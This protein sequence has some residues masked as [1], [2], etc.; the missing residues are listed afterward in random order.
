MKTQNYRQWIISLL[1]LFLFAPVFYGEKIFS[2]YF[3]IVII[4]CT[5]PFF[6]EYSSVFPRLVVFTSL[7][8]LL[9]SGIRHTGNNSGLIIASYSFILI[10]TFYDIK[11]IGKILFYSGILILTFFIV[12]NYKNLIINGFEFY[13]L[14]DKFFYPHLFFILAVISLLLNLFSG[15]FSKSS[16]EILNVL[17]IGVL[18]FLVVD[19]FKIYKKSFLFS[20]FIIKENLS[21]ENFYIDKTLSVAAESDLSNDLKK[22]V[23]FSE[24]NFDV[25]AVMTSSYHHETKIEKV[26]TFNKKLFGVDSKNIY[27]INKKR[28]LKKIFTLNNG[29]IKDFNIYQNHIYF[30][31]Y[32]GNLFKKHIDENLIENITS[33]YG[34]TE[35]FSFYNGELIK[36]NNSWS[37]SVFN[38]ERNSDFYNIPYKKVVFDSKFYYSIS[39]N[40]INSNN[41]FSFNVNEGKASRVFNRNINIYDFAINSNGEILFLDKK[42]DYKCD[43]IYYDKNKNFKIL[44]YS[45]GSGFLNFI[46]DE[47]F[48]II[49]DN[50]I[51]FYKL[52]N[53]PTYIM[54]G[55]TTEEKLKVVEKIIE[56]NNGIKTKIQY[57]KKGDFFTVKISNRSKDLNVIVSRLVF[58]AGVLANLFRFEN[59]Q[60]GLII[61]TEFYKDKILIST[62][63]RIFAD[64]LNTA[65]P[66]YVAENINLKINNTTFRVKGGI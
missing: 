5:Y 6:F 21:I 44:P 30:S 58:S 29:L 26:L 4:F 23:V 24:K 39:D 52:E 1:I 9:F 31:D 33:E 46:N 43:L 50:L 28:E 41:L 27:E 17:I 16:I 25:Y 34:K 55:E 59:P 51:T 32:E 10:L 64:A 35:F 36:Y 54:I 63:V 49:D 37:G 14:G 11:K 60:S 48:A 66:G 47:E 22:Y 12:L 2:L 42:S 45:G 38:F 7:S 53:I 20:D 40:L 3:F 56:K 8:V 61:E 13:L 18:F 62:G 65:S 15:I 57:D 19:Y